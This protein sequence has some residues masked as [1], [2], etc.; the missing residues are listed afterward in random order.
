MK[1]ASNEPIAAPMVLNSVTE[2]ALF[3]GLSR[4]P[5]TADDDWER[6]AAEK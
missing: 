2:P 4:R 1:L 6:G 5:N 3:M